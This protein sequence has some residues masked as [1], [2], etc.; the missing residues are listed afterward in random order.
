MRNAYLNWTI[1]ICYNDL[2][3]KQRSSLNSS[4]ASEKLFV[5]HRIPNQFTSVLTFGEHPVFIQVLWHNF[6]GQ[7]P[8]S[9]AKMGLL[10]FYKNNIFGLDS[11]AFC[12]EKKSKR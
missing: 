7:I 5:S 9:T 12:P 4:S 1:A 6:E 10:V 11:D 8:F 3:Q 2:F